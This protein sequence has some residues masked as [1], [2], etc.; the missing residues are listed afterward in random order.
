MNYVSNCKL[1]KVARAG[2]MLETTTHLRCADNTEKLSSSLSKL[3]SVVMQF[4]TPVLE[5]QTIH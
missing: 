5:A 4:S 1:C 3:F 2:E